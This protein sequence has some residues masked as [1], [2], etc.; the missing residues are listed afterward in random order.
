MS[1]LIEDAS[2]DHDSLRRLPGKI[3][4]ITKAIDSDTRY[5]CFL[6]PDWKGRLVVYPQPSSHPPLSD[7]LFQEWLSQG[8]ALAIARYLKKVHLGQEDQDDHHLQQLLGFF[9]RRC[10]TPRQVYKWGMHQNKIRPYD[11]STPAR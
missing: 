9:T 3:H 11:R 10:G 7:S 1:I 8:Y 4:T 6:P 2:E 5:T